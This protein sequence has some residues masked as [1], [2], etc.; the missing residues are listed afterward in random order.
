MESSGIFRA[1]VIGLMAAG[2]A[3]CNYTAND[4]I[5]IADGASH[6]GDATTINGDVDVGTNADASDSNF[7]TV[8]GRIVVRDG[9]QVNDCATVN[10]SMK[11]GE[12]AVAGDLRTVNGDLRV[13]RDSRVEGRIQL[14][15]GSVELSPGAFVDGDVGTI[16]GKIEM[17]S[18]QVDGDLSNVNGGMLITQGSEV[19]GDL[20]VREAG[21]D[22]HSQPPVIVIGPDARVLGS[23]VF[24]RPV[25]LHVHVS[26]EI[27]EVTG[28]EVNRFSGNEPG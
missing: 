1:V 8:N 25:E 19:R 22:R 13:G 7:K 16:N 10:G 27:G 18:A 4:D 6:R 5:E 2:L 12:G 11:V 28:A 23:L 24:E 14:V 17:H 3:A 21:D 15:N 20:T 9:A 26:A